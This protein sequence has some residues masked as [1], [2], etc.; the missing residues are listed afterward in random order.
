[1]RKIKTIVLLMAIAIGAQADV[2]IDYSHFPDMHFRKYVTQRYDT[3]DDGV[4]STREAALA[5]TIDL[6]GTSVENLKGIEYFKNLTKLDISESLVRTL[7]LSGNEELT[8]LNCTH[9]Y[10][11]KLDLSNNEKLTELYCSRTYIDGLDLRNNRYLQKL[12]C[13]NC[14]LDYLIISGDSRDLSMVNCSS[15]SMTEAAL[16]L[17]I[18]RLR[19]KVDGQLYVVQDVNTDYDYTMR[20]SNEFTKKLAAMVFAKGWT[21]YKGTYD[22]NTGKSSWVAYTN[23]NYNYKADVNED[24]TVDSADIVAVIKGMK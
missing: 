21:P 24:G 20:D 1:M 19:V 22:E 2:T 13:S 6:R 4:L 8:Y 3:N 10:I 18:S 7:D 9:S 15:N 5:V 12:D 11:S 17:F 14:H 23:D 16:E